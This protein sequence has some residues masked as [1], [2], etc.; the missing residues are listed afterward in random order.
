MTY[1]IYQSSLGVEGWVK[2]DLQAKDFR[3]AMD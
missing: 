3:T 1:H 2:E